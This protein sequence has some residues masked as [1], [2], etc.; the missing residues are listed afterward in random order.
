MKK[1]IYVGFVVTIILQ[2]INSYC[3]KF[4]K[5]FK[6]NLIQTKTNSDEYQVIDLLALK[7]NIMTNSTQLSDWLHSVESTLYESTSF[8]GSMSFR[9]MVRKPEGHTDN[10]NIRPQIM[11]SDWY[12]AL[13][14]LDGKHFD[15]DEFRF[16]TPI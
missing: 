11:F 16:Y 7:S 14:I 15:E 3:Y 1:G 9:Y 13:A 12:K 5:D 4:Y 8:D 2:E 10:A 6:L